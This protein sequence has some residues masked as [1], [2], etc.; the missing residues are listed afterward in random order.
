[1]ASLTQIFGDSIT[2]VTKTLVNNGYS[3]A[4][5]REA[6]QSAIHILERVG[7]NPNGLV[8]MLREMDRRL[9]PG[10]LDFAKTH[11][12][13]TRRIEDVSFLIGPYRPVIEPEP[14]KIRFN[15]TMAQ[16]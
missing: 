14:R 12:A 5:E 7:Y 2:D 9:K 16:T 4:F 6:D 1:M 8:D 3:R 10:G 11:P 15:R 13:P